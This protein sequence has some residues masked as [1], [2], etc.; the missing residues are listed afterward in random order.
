LAR[1]LNDLNALGASLV[2]LQSDLS[3][4]HHQLSSFAS[5]SPTVHLQF[6]VSS[7]RGADSAE[8]VNFGMKCGAGAHS[9]RTSSQRL[10]AK[11]QENSQGILAPLLSML[12]GATDFWKGPSGMERSAFPMMRKHIALQYLASIPMSTE[13]P[14]DESLLCDQLPSLHS[15]VVRFN[16]V[17]KDR[18]VIDG[19]FIA[20]ANLPL[21]TIQAISHRLSVGHQTTPLA[22]IHIPTVLFCPPN[23]GFYECLV[24]AQANSSWLGFY[25]SKGILSECPLPSAFL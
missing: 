3:S 10:K 7:Q 8:L 15:R 23:A 11:Q 13:G 9:L 5:H 1:A 6:F 18:N 2:S 14:L 22:P 24:M 19:L 12:S 16:I 17:G 20:H 25:L 4:L 21:S